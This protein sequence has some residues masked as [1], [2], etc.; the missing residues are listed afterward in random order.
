M[1]RSR[2]MPQLHQ[3]PAQLLLQHYCAALRLQHVSDADARQLL[4]EQQQRG[5]QVLEALPQGVLLL[6]LLLVAAAVWEQG[7]LEG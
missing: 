3:V 4:K 5:A 7:G 1:L 2:P 6:L